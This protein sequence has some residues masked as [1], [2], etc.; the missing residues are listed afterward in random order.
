M[1]VRIPPLEVKIL[2]E[3]NPLESRILVRRLAVRD[4]ELAPPPHG[5][6]VHG[7]FSVKHRRDLWPR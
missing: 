2:L 4:K 3:S 5:V 6:G 7:A 1:D